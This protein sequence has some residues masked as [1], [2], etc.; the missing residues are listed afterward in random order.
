[1]SQGT[2]D[3]TQEEGSPVADTATDETQTDD[4]AE[5]APAPEAE[6]AAEATPAAKEPALQYEKDVV[7]AEALVEPED[8]PEPV[9]S[10]YDRPGK[11]YVVHTQSGYEKKVKS[12]LEARTASM[13]MEDSIF[14]VAIPLEDVVE[15]KNGKRV[16]VQKKMFP[17]YLLVRCRLDDDSWY[18]IRNTPGVTG[19]VGAGAK[20]S[21][22]RRKDVENFLGTKDEDTEVTAAKIKPR[23]QYEVGETVRVKDGPFA[24]FSGE[25]IELNAEQ[26]KV[27]V[28]VNIFGRETPVELEF[29]Q[30]AKL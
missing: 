20:P 30:V 14:E 3:T 15:V 22:L 19:F 7:D 2:P 10:P 11:W 5:A 24:D 12:N 9:V 18:V 8:E 28:L 1:M 16:V 27:K 17:G 4:A 21:P 29:S 25:V 26:L 13:N 23:L 6:P